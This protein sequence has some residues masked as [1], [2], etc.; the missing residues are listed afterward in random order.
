MVCRINDKFYRSVPRKVAIRSTVHG[1]LSTANAG[2]R[3]FRKRHLFFA[4]IQHAPIL[5]IH[6]ELWTVDCIYAAVNDASSLL[7]SMV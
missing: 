7:L 2:W 4:K 3:G 1:P 6:S 5:L